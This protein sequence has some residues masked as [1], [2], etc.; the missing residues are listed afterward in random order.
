M[1]VC[2]RR[3]KRSCVRRCDLVGHVDDH[4]SRMT[5]SCFLRNPVRQY[6]FCQKN[7]SDGSEA[8]A[9]TNTRCDDDFEG[10]ADVI[11]LPA[12]QRLGFRQLDIWA[13]P[14]SSSR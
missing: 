6:S 14:I 13:S 8:T 5:A 1:S 4:P 2:L 11:G 7:E 12:P 3:E 9:Q 10:V